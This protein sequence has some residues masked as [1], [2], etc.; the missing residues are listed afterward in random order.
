MCRERSVRVCLC[1]HAC[2]CVHVWTLCVRAEA[3]VAERRG[4]P[5]ATGGQVWVRFFL[6]HR[7]V[8]RSGW[9]ESELCVLK[10]QRGLDS[11]DP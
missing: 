5:P 1:E 2:L 10:P 7:Q 3:N 11:A 8:G 4:G 9:Q 6:P